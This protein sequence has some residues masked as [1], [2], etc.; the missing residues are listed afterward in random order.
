MTPDSIL[1]EG[2]RAHQAGR[3]AEA[4]RHYRRL[5]AQQPKH[6]GALHY[7][8]LLAF[9]AQRY[10]IAVQLIGLSIAEKADDPTAHVNLG[11]ALA[12]LARVADAEAAFRRAIALDPGLADA[13]FN[14]GNI[15]REQQRFADA[16]TAYR[17]VIALRPNHVGALKNLANLLLLLG[18]P[19]ESA[20]AWHYAGNVLQDIGQIDDAANAYRQA[21]ALSPSPGV[22]VKL[23]LLAPAIP[24]SVAEIDQTRA[25]LV[26]GMDALAA[27]GIRLPDP[28]RYA[29]SAVFY[30]PYHGR[31]DRELRTRI[32]EF[33][34]GASPH[35]AWRAPHCTNYR[36]AGERIRI[37]FISRHFHREHPMTKLFGG[38]VENL[39]RRHFDVSVFR[40]DR[41][42][43][44]TP[45]GESRVT[46]LG[47]DLAAA[48]RTLADARLD[49]LF[50]TDIGME[51]TTYFL[52]FARLAPVQCVTFGHPVTTALANVDYF[53]SSQELERADAEDHYTETLIRLATVPTFFRRPS[54][55]AVAPTRADLGLPADARIYFCAQNVIKYHPDF[56][57]II[58]E[59]LRRDPKG[60]FVLINSS[61]APQLGELLLARFRQS[62]PDV[63][64]R[65]AFMPF[66]DLDALLGF[67][68]CVDAI[69]DTPVF[70]G[71]TTSLEMF[72]V[73]AP[74]VTWPG[75]FARSRITH[76]LYRQI[77]VEGLAA[78]SA[79]HYIELALRLANDLAWR[80]ELQDELRQK[81]HALYE[82]VALVRELERFFAAAVAAAGAGRKVQ[83]CAGNGPWSL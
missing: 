8:G 44:A 31:N 6:P 23:A 39:D 65:V 45:L 42:G 37:G 25:R 83:D 26:A 70:G 41:Q 61:K 59:I 40:F 51:P 55:A 56:D 5:L 34:L 68:P 81:K 49:V 75:P 10:D 15:L 58:G 4:E 67:L 12:M 22:E 35:L 24:M 69:L 16:D 11:N 71:G 21:L 74:I 1:Q 32:A 48:R 73:D 50:Y 57:A 47:D 52:A 46:V 43:A 64:H 20:E 2:L 9:Q 72:A 13:W 54:P 82:N 77:G 19:E 36:G 7:M 18:R 14:L 66:L 27:K 80:K 76:A 38:I 63:V 78:E 60:L 62:M 29:G 17:R 33:Y 3:L 79:P 30:T 28:L 53:L